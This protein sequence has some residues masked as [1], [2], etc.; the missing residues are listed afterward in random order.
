M[1]RLFLFIS[2]FLTSHELAAKDKAKKARAL[3][4]KEKEIEKI[5]QLTQ[6]EKYIFESLKTKYEKTS[7]KSKLFSQVYIQSLKLS[8]FKQHLIKKLQ[9]NYSLEELKTLSKLLKKPFMQKIFLVELRSPQ[10]W[11]NQTLTKNMLTLTKESKQRERIKK[12]SRSLPL[13]KMYLSMAK[14]FEPLDLSQEIYFRHQR[15]QGSSKERRKENYLESL[16]KLSE[17]QKDREIEFTE[18]MADFY[19]QEVLDSEVREF[20]RISKKTQLNSFLSRTVSEFDR[21]TRS[22]AKANFV[23]LLKTVAKNNM[24]SI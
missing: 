11:E 17:K 10:A 23:R 13:Y 6:L 2:L 20:L 3:N 9:K 21:F 22:H 7:G 8:N 19:Q 14:Y 15:I 1:L 24:A 18:K 4:L 12:L 5:I 16:T